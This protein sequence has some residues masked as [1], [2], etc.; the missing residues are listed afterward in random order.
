MSSL[1]RKRLALMVL[2]LAMIV[3]FIIGNP[4]Y[5]TMQPESYKNLQTNRSKI[6]DTKTGHINE[7]TE[8]AL[9]KA[10]WSTADYFL[11]RHWW[12]YDES[13]YNYD[14]MEEFLKNNSPNLI[15][16]ISFIDGFKSL[17]ST[18]CFI[19]PVFFLAII[20]IKHKDD[21][22]TQRNRFNN[23]SW[24]LL[25]FTV[26]LIYGLACIRFP[27]RVAVPIYI[28]LL[29]LLVIL[30]PSITI[31]RKLQYRVILVAE[32]ALIIMVLD[33]VNIKA[34]SQQANNIKF[35][36][37]QNEGKIQT[38]QQYNGADTYFINLTPPLV[39]IEGNPITEIRKSISYNDVPGGWL[40]GTDQYYNYLAQYE[41]NSG[42]QLIESS[43]DN[44]KT[45]FYF[46]QPPIKEYY[47]EFT[48][49]IIE[50]FEDHYGQT[51]RRFKL[52]ILEDTRLM[53]KAGNEVGWVYF[54]IK[55][56]NT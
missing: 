40:I 56:V 43:I 9:K 22:S 18:S 33:C 5:Q 8:I 49:H 11:L 42:K 54:I 52:D 44:P 2:P 31:K 7:N 23:L 55:T 46:Y 16:A 27:L 4:D 50:H 15:D 6:L 37:E 30:R 32:V 45:V 51:G 24:G 26:A 12:T 3:A 21:L 53:D 20:L 48:K 41:F 1:G 14:K 29:M 25:M 36:K 13:I 10:D 28:Y 19:F 38:I 34:F 47:S 17:Y 39:N 35:F